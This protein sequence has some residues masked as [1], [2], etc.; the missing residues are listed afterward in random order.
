M[1]LELRRMQR[2]VRLA[3]HLLLGML[4]AHLVLRTIKKLAHRLPR[5][6][7]YA[8]AVVQWWNRKLCRIINLRIH[9]EGE[10]NAHPTLFVANHISWLD[11]TCLA[12]KLDARFVAKREVRDWPLFGAMAT[13]NH[14]LFIKRGDASVTATVAD[15]M[16]WSL[17]QKNNF[18]VFPEGTSSGGASVERFHARLFQSAIRARAQVQAVAITYPHPHGTNPAAPFVGEDNLLRHL[19]GVLREPAID[20][21][22]IFCKSLAAEGMDRRALATRTRNQIL[23]AFA[24]TAMEADISA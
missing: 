7:R 17:L 6:Q 16:T 2:L 9:I 14:T 21:S 23:A 18:I 1:I 5:H 13:R 12:G 15:Q 19:W 20:I 4:A 11:I 10:I 8:Q 3:W 22:L 24:T